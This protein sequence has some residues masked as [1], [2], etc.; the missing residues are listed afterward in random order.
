MGDAQTPSISAQN[1]ILTYTGEWSSNGNSSLKIYSN[2]NKTFYCGPQSTNLG[3]H[4]LCIGKTIQFQADI[5]T[6]IPLYLRVFI[7]VNDSWSSQSVLISSSSNDVTVTVDV[8]EDCS[9]L[10]FRVDS[11]KGYDDVT[12]YTDN[13]RLFV[14]NE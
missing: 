13:W 10:W 7:N 1:C 4:N 3:I 2:T 14:L 9:N 11:T 12:V 5:N 8:P 6:D